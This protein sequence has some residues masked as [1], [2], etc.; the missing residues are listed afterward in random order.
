MVIPLNWFEFVFLL[1]FSHVFLLFFCAHF[2]LKLL[3]PIGYCL[4]WCNMYRIISYRIDS[5]IQNLPIHSIFNSR[6]NVHSIFILFYF[7]CA[8]F[9]IA[10]A[11]YFFLIT[12]LISAMN[13]YCSLWNFPFCQLFLLE[14]VRWKRTHKILWLVKEVTLLFSD[15]KRQMDIEEVCIKWN[16]FV[17]IF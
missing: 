12:E 4:P 6:R 10:D 9:G 14:G 7:V 17:V 2:A 16:S 5:N 13:P 15:H 11:L 1:C 3:K 8:F